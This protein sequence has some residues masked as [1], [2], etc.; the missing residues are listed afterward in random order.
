MKSMIFAKKTGQ[1]RLYQT[2]TLY[3][4]KAAPL[5]KIYYV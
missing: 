3:I 2:T 4:K 5:Q 1:R